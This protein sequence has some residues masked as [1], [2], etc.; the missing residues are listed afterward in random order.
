VLLHVPN[1]REL[2]YGDTDKDVESSLALLIIACLVAI[3]SAEIL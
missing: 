1:R 2:V 3:A